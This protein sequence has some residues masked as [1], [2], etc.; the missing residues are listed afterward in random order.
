MADVIDDVM[1]AMCASC[2]DPYVV[3]EGW[4]GRCA[5]CWALSDEHGALLHQGRPVVECRECMVGNM[6]R[7]RATA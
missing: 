6:T 7:L 2:A 5:S 4:D 1:I 3:P